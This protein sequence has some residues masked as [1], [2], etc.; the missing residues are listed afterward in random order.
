MFIW[1]FAAGLFMIG[2]G[3][4]YA[5]PNMD[6]T[7]TAPAYSQINA[8]SMD[9]SLPEA[10]LGSVTIDQKIITAKI[11]SNSSDG[12]KLAFT[13][14][15]AGKL[16]RTGGSAANSYDRI[17]YTLS[18]AKTSND[19]GLGAGLT[20]PSMLSQ[21]TLATTSS[22]GSE[23]KFLGTATSLTTEYKLDLYVKV[24]LAPGP[25]PQSLSIMEGS[26]ADTIGITITNN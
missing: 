24:G 20:A 25:V 17:G 26:Y 13:S 6:I 21:V 9:F 7:G 8:V 18:S 23:L 16:V 15:N 2:S 22:A 4:A 11:D 14:T 1:F 19:A 3:I 5:E 12:F 10:H